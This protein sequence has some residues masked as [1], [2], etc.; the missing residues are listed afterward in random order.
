[1]ARKISML[2]PDWWDFT[3]LPDELL[4]EAARLTPDDM[5]KLSRKG[6]KVIFYDKLEDFTL[7]KP[8]NIL[9]PGNRLQQISLSASA[10]PSDL[11]NSFP[12]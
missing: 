7:L 8:L 1:M 6:F 3:T 10:A 9:L 2:A 5:L 11:P 4:N 12:W